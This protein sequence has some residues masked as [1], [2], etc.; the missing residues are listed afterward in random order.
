MK[1]TLS[2]FATVLAAVINA[3]TPSTSL[4]YVDTTARTLTGNIVAGN[5]TTISATG[6]GTITATA[7]PLTGIT[8]LGTGVSTFLATPSSANLASAVTN[9]TGSGALVFA[10]SPTLVTPVLGAATGTSLSLTGAATSN[11]AFLVDT[12]TSFVSHTATAGKLQAQTSWGGVLSGFGTTNDVS[13]FNKSG[14]L[15]LSIPTGT[16]NV[17]I[18]G[19][20][21]IPDGTTAAPSLTFAA[22]TNTGIARAATDSLEITA[23]G[24]RSALFTSTGQ[25][26]SG[27]L[28]VSGTGTST[29]GGT[30]RAG[31]GSGE[32]LS[33]GSVDV[34]GDIGIKSTQG[35][36]QGNAR[37]VTFTS[38][39]TSLAGNLTVSGSGGT[40]TSDVTLGTSGPSVKSSLGARAPRQGLVFD[41]THNASATVTNVPAFG[42][43]DFTFAAWV[44][45]DSSFAGTPIIVIGNGAGGFYCEFNSSGIPYVGIQGG[46][47]LYS[48]GTCVVGK[49]YL[50][51]YTRSGTTGTWYINGVST[52]S[53]TDGINYTLPFANVSYTAPY[54]LNG[55]CYPLAYNRALSAAEVLALYESGAPAASDYNSA[56]NTSLFTG[57]NSDFS[58]AGNWTVNGSTTISGGKLNLNNTDQAYNTVFSCT[59]GQRFR[60]TVTV[61]SLTAGTVQYYNNGWVTFA[62]AAGT[63]TVDVT[64]TVQL[65][66]FN[67][68]TNGG[69]AVLDTCLIYKTGLLL[70]PD[71]QQV[72]GGS[73]WADTSGNKAHI[74]LPASGV[75]WN[76]PSQI[77]EYV[78]AEL[79]FSN[80]TALTDSTAK[81]VTSI[82]LTAGDWDV[83]GVIGYYATSATALNFYSGTNTTSATFGADRSYAQRY[84]VL[85][86]ATTGMKDAVPVNRIAITSTTTVYLVARADFSAGT[87][88]AWG[89][90]RARRVR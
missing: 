14:G 73:V 77:G 1:K 12:N 21:L 71:A 23:G 35:I 90:I 55:F 62:S 69:N 75:S 38:G 61:D 53:L 15:A 41:S 28:T 46:S 2:L 26:I 84:T 89:T 7:A 11:N 57:A 3:A 56:S 16:T 8:G 50:L 49:T 83:T 51:T 81:N 47:T 86:A 52:N 39:N 65:G 76:V 74:T 42:T 30:V 20:L 17:G 59:Q 54:G 33:A 10:T 5:N 37:I 32:T 31:A 88:E 40:T 63:Y 6:N 36:V 79:T 44:R 80:R 64:A 34:T 43:S 72:G 24:T 27:N 70:A 29:F 9:E 18:A 66:S 22:D 25:T 67:L 85:T 19:T 45:E 58:S 82:T 78:D 60:F 4:V 87:I 68:R 13:I 48:T